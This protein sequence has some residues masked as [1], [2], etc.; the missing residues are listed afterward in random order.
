MKERAPF[1]QLVSVSLMLLAMAG[2]ASI[3]SAATPA[4]TEFGCTNLVTPERIGQE[5]FERYGIAERLQS[6]EFA[7]SESDGYIVCHAGK[8]RYEGEPYWLNADLVYLFDQWTGELVVTRIHWDGRQRERAHIPVTLQ[9]TSGVVT[10]GGTDPQR[11]CMD[12]DTPI[13]EIGGEDP[14]IWTLWDIVGGKCSA[15]ITG[16]FCFDCGKEEP[17]RVLVPAFDYASA[18]L[19][20]GAPD[21]MVCLDVRTALSLSGEGAEAAGAGRQAGEA[22]NFVL[23]GGEVCWECRQPTEEGESTQQADLD[24]PPAESTEPASKVATCRDYL[25]P[26]TTGHQKW[27]DYGIAEMLRN[28]NMQQ[29]MCRGDDCLICY[30]RRMI[31]DVWVPGDELYYRFDLTTGELVQVRVHWR[32]DLPEHLPAARL[33]QQEAEELVAGKVEHAF[34]GLLSPDLLSFRTKKQ[35]SYE[36]P[37][38]FVSSITGT[39]LDIPRVTVIDAVT[40]E[41]YGQYCPC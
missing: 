34:L 28:G 11:V 3:G 21:G 22:C 33:S 14:Q 38:W 17:W 12:S 41:I 37:C 7:I 20:H 26:E 10:A 39:K 9:Q 29:V 35:V 32:E 23:G 27:D 18:E 30:G 16:R 31:D 2:L 6:D 1:R 8:P 13:I 15:E 40:G 25:T 19:V 36:N 24:E 5:E 4:T